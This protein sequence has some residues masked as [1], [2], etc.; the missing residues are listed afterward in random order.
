MSRNNDIWQR[1]P[2]GMVLGLDFSGERLTSPT[3]HTATANNGAAVN[4]GTRYVTLDGV[5]DYLSAPDDP[6]FSFTDGAGQD[7]PATLMA[8]VYLD[9]SANQ[10]KVIS[11]KAESTSP[12]RMEW[13]FVASSSAFAY[14]GPAFGLYNSDASTTTFAAINSN[15]IPATTWTHVAAVYQGGG[16][17]SSINI[18]VNG[19][20]LT[21]VRT[22]GAGY[23]GMS[24]TS[25]KL[26]IGSRELSGLYLGG[27]IADFR[28]YNRELTQPEIAQI[29]N[30]GAARIA[31]GGTP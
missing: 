9:A 5:N 27:R 13:V 8:W 12:A 23:A 6:S 31:Q 20:D 29:Y 4:A 26:T 17:A 15:V 11:A 21:D 25:A 10:T 16:L 18:Y 28:I 22:N 14:K 1:K 7:Q 19:V 24:N 30:A 2:A 3:G